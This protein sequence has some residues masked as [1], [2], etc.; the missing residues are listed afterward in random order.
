MIEKI[1]GKFQRESINLKLSIIVFCFLMIRAFFRNYLF[2]Y[3]TG[4]ST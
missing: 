3:Y 4:L 2:T 1:D